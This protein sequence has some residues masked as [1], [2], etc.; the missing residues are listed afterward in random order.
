MFYKS[1]TGTE[2]ESFSQMSICI[3]PLIPAFML[4]CKRKRNALHAALEMHQS[5][6]LPTVVLSGGHRPSLKC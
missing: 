1:I 2:G 4:S 3:R 6:T 5:I